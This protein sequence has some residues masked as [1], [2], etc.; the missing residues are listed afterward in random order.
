MSAICFDWIFLAHFEYLEQI[1]EPSLHEVLECE[2]QEVSIRE[3]WMG[4]QR[5]IGKVST[6]QAQHNSSR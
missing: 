5:L 1:E 4:Q 6:V 3:F 2:D